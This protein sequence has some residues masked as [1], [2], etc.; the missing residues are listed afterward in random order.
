MLF[1]GLGSVVFVREVKLF[2]YLV[3]GVFLLNV[4]FR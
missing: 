3:V 1:E 4:C 2:F